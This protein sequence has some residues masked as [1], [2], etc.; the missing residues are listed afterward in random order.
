MNEQ[1]ILF[2][3]DYSKWSQSAYQ[4]IQSV[5]RNTD[6][7]FYERGDAPSDTLQTWQ[8]DW[9]I[10]FKSELL[11][12]QV[13]LKK[14]RLGAINFHPSPPKYRGIGG[15]ILALRNADTQFGVTCH[16]MNNTI[17]SGQII[18]T[19]YFDIGKDD[20]LLTL[21]H[22]T[23]LHCLKLLFDIVE[24]IYFEIPFPKSSENWG[25]QLYKYADFKNELEILKSVETKES[26]YADVAISYQLSKQ[27][28][29]K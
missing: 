20:S 18:K 17:D 16:Y 29:K 19:S 5:F 26:K 6:N 3:S 10:S 1:K 25:K 13:F 8:G 23:A 28:N 9:I 4:Y 2:I 14:A 15:Y 22:K 11:L 27:S 12:P 21:Y 24:H 7:V